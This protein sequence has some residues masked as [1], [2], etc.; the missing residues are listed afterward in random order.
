[1]HT[2]DFSPLYRSTVGFDR[3][4]SLLNATNQNAQ[5][6]YPPYNIEHVDENQYRISM[7][8]AGFKE[9]E[10]E[11]VTEPNSLVVTGKTK[12]TKERKF[13]YQGIATRNFE[14]K[15]QLAD[16]VKVVSAHLEDGLL[17]IELE[18][19]IPEAMKPR[20]IKITNRTE[21]NDIV[22]GKVEKIEAKKEGSEAA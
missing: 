10:I 6:G 18:R 22:N 14:R 19:E 1:M 11:M 12:P 16:Y 8:V 7:A 2:I 17:H 21:P 20:T 13:L 5:A 4:A 3:L 15:F 9:D